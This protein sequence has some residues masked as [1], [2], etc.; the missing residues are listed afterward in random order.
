MLME[1]GIIKEKIH[2]FVRD[3]GSNMIRAMKLGDLPD[4]SCT[5]QIAQT[6]LHKIQKEQLNQ[7][8]LS[9]K[10][11]C[12]TRWNSSFHMLERMIKIQDSLCLYACKHN[13]S[14]LSPEEWLQLKKIVTILQPFEE[15]TRN[16]SDN[17]ASISS[18][19]PLIHT[20]KYTLQTE[21]SK[22]DTNEKFNSIIKCTVDQL[23]S[24]F[25]DLQTNNFFAIATY[26]DPRYKTKF[27]NEVV[28]E[29]I[30]T[31]IMSLFDAVADTSKNEADNIGAPVEKRARM[32][33]KAEASHSN[34][35]TVL[36]NILL[37]SDSDED[38]DDT[39]SGRYAVFDKF[40]VMKG[41]LNEYNKEKRISI[42][43]D[44]L[45]WWKV[46]GNTKFQP[47]QS[48]ARQYL[49]CPPGSVAS[50]QLFSGAGLIYDSLRNTLD[51]DKA[52][53]LLFIKYNTL[54]LESI[55]I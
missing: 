44:P 8:C 27:F 3:S 55:L 34:V 26:L 37:S 20:L 14:Q 12:S 46:N 5:V 24:K 41:M 31:E 15:I 2:C 28:K 42:S 53:K 40:V 17:N 7:E 29:N 54:L 10:Q 30:E 18:V 19:I 23:N 6:E 11:D 21:A 52:S 39:T 43:D 33:L 48:I 45:L 25:G 35:Q 16:M 13:I 4:V 22:Q 50:E 49:P 1:W 51:G 32:E 38:D 47:L 36:S 9:V